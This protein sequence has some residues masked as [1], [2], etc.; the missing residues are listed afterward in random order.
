MTAHPYQMRT[1]PRLPDPAA[2][3]DF[4]QGVPTKRLIAWVIDMALIAILAAMALPFTAFLGVFFFPFLM[5][6]IGF[7]YRWFTLASGSA[8]WGMRMMSLEIRE[9]DGR[10]LSSQTAFLHTMGYTIS[11]AMPILQLISIGLMLMSERKQGL[12]DHILGT[13]ALNRAV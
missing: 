8:T 4:Y 6:V 3:P 11:L 7:F 2:R 13:A 10:F 5:L 9:A 1:A 12:T